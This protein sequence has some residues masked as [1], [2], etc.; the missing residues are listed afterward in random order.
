MSFKLYIL[1]YLSKLA[2]TRYLL[3]LFISN[4]L[5]DPLAPLSFPT[6]NISN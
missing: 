1:A 4:Y 6:I 3:S 2:E 5:I